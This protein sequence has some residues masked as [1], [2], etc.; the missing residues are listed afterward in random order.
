MAAG[1]IG[2]IL[3]KMT[4]KPEYISQEV[5]YGGSSEPITPEEYTTNGGVQEFRFTY[6]LKSAFLGSGIAG[7]PQQVPGDG[8]LASEI[9]NVFVANHDTERVRAKLLLRPLVLTW[10]LLQHG[11]TSLTYKDGGNTYT[12]AHVF[13]LAYPYGVPTVLSAYEFDNFD[14]G[15]PNGAAGSCY[16]QGGTEGWCV[17]RQ[18]EA[19]CFLTT[20]LSRRLC[21]HRWAA[22]EGMNAF[23]IAVSGD[24]GNIQ[25]GSQQ[26]L[27]FSRGK[28][29]QRCSE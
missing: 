6:A 24:V 23:R 26:Q 2:A 12:L 15:P 25:T 4:S 22:I 7:L 3:N 10:W 5:I 17:W 19:T 8:W 29:D 28:L 9:A 11:P 1:D 13:M 14:A 27:A 16:A 18:H 21:Q 20:F